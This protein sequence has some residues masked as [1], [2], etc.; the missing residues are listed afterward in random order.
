MVKPMLIRTKGLGADYTALALAIQQQEGYYPGSRSWTN[1]NPGNLM[2]A[3]QVGSTGPDAQGFA[4]FPDY[5]TGF[6]ALIN[7]VTLDAS[8]GLSVSQFTAKYAPAASG[9]DPAAYARNISAALGLSPSDPLAAAD[10][11]VSDA[12]LMGGLLPNLGG[13]PMWGWVLAAAAGIFLAGE[14]LD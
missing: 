1:N 5:S 9:N 2:Y 12:S 13:I 7:Q 6:Q 11:Q 10:A 4:T 3:G 14:V 8:R